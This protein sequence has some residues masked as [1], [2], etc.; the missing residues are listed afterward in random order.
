[1]MVRNLTFNDV[2]KLDEVVDFV[3]GGAAG[4]VRE[5]TCYAARFDSVGRIDR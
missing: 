3:T 2:E 5:A 4:P 1:M